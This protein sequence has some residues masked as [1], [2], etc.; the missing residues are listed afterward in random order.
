MK[1]FFGLT[2]AALIL[3][4]TGCT[5]FNQGDE[6]PY[7]E[8][9]FYQKY[10]NPQSALDRQ[11]TGVVDALRANPRAASLHNELGQ[12]LITKGFPKD[13][14]QEFERAINEDSKFYPAWYN[15]GLVRMSRGEVLG[16]RHAF[17]RTVA[18]KPGHAQ[19]LFQLGL[20]EEKR[21][22]R[23][24]AVDLYA[25]AYKINRS[26]LSPRVNPLILDSKL[27]HLAMIQLYPTAHARNAM[28]FHPAPPGYVDRQPEAPSPEATPQQIVPPTAPAT[29]PAAQPVRPPGT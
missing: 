2:L 24:R 27:T 1:R 25:K 14:E 21:G 18:Y 17:G 3:A 10:L 11:I 20:L 15:L 5:Y 4:A 22:N 26:L 9:L 7:D 6:N 16:A 23:D 13:A 12:L 29:D 19:A 8:P 28:Q